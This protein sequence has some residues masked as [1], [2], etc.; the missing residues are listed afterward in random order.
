MS[1]VQSLS[2]VQLFV[3]PWT[4]ALQASL[5]ITNSRS[6][7]KLM[8]IESVMPSNHL[9]LCLPLL[10]PSIFPSIRVFSNESVLCIKW[11]K[12][13]SFSLNISPSNEYSGLIPLGWT[14]WVSLLSKGLSR[15]FSNTTAQNCWKAMTTFTFLHSQSFLSRVVATPVKG[16]WIA[17]SIRRWRQGPLKRRTAFSPW[18]P[19]LSF[20]R[21]RGLKTFVL[22]Q[23]AECLF[24]SRSTS[25]LSFGVVGRKSNCNCSSYIIFKIQSPVAQTPR[26]AQL[27]GSQCSSLGQ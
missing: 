27:S 4:S 9:I 8:S 7:L 25:S 19:M 20:Q 14:G 6:L 24:I 21:A 26:I 1:S 5:S 2:H 13:W 11:P 18:R 17:M 22:S 16:V 12:Y 23:R 3:T 15:V 10:P